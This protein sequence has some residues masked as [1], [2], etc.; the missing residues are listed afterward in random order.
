MAP[1]QVWAKLLVCTG[2]DDPSVPGA[3]VTACAEEMSKAGV[4]WQIISYGGT[5]HGFTYPD[6][7]RRGIPWIAYNKPADE[8]LWQAMRAFFEEIFGAA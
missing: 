4:D 6:A 8:R 2:A 7:A 1:G 5:T 3:H